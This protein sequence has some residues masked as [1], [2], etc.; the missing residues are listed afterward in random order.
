[1]EKECDICG[2]ICKTTQGLSGHMRFKHNKAVRSEQD[3]EQ[4][5]EQ[6][7][8]SDTENLHS[9]YVDITPPQKPSVMPQH[10]V[11]EDFEGFLDK[12]LRIKGKIMAL[13]TMDM[14]VGQLRQEMGL[15]QPQQKSEIDMFQK[16]INLQKNMEEINVEKE[17]R[18][19][20]KILEELESNDGEETDPWL[21]IV[22]ELMPVVKAKFSQQPQQQQTPTTPTQQ[23]PSQKIRCTSPTFYISRFSCF[24]FFNFYYDKISFL[25]YIPIIQINK[26]ARSHSSI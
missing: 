15:E 2:V 24:A 7:E 17:E 11:E 18:L 21:P 1:M 3:S 16:Y 22:K 13:K 12:Q 5:V 26:F 14:P 23:Q 20:N 10:K 9:K 6:T 19:K 8:Y 4:Y 25:F